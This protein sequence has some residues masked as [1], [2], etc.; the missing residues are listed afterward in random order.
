MLR[1]EFGIN[2]GWFWTVFQF[3][4]VCSHVF[5]EQLGFSQKTRGPLYDDNVVVW[6]GLG[7][8]KC[9]VFPCNSQAALMVRLFVCGDYSSIEIWVHFSISLVYRSPKKTKALD[10]ARQLANRS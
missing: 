5:L 10:V 1:V 7:S 3:A 6:I 9:K 4:D 2:F 8:K